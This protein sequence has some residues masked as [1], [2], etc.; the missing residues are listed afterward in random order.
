VQQP[1]AAQL[2]VE[3]DVDDE[4]AVRGAV[5]ADRVAVGAEQ[6]R[7]RDGIAPVR[8]AL[9]GALQARVGEGAPQL[10]RM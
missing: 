5:A 7:G 10:L 9:P 8:E 1:L 6:L 2:A 3:D 4:E